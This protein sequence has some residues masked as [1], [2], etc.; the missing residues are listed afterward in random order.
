M[1]ASRNDAFIYDSKMLKN[2][3]FFVILSKTWASDL[4]AYSE[5]TYRKKFQTFAFFVFF[6]QNF[7]FLKFLEFLKLNFAYFQKFDF[8]ERYVNSEYAHKKSL[9]LGPCFFSRK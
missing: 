6:N 1:N 7:I 5:F 2:Q 8:D 4:W 9:I 3:L